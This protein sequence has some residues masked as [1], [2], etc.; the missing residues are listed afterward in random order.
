MFD[1]KVRVR[2]TSLE[3]FNFIEC[4]NLFGS[5]LGLWPG[6]GLCQVLEGLL[7]I[8]LVREGGE[9]EGT[10]MINSPVFINFLLTSEF[11]LLPFETSSS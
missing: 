10:V 9:K 8:F 11:P 2:K 5:N 1:P 4:L 3:K 7:G 6:I